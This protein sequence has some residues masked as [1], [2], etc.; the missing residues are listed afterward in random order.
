[1][2]RTLIFA[3]L[4][5]AVVPA[6]AQ[7]QEAACSPLK[8]LA[9]IKLNRKAEFTAGEIGDV[10]TDLELADELGAFELARAQIVPKPVFSI[11]ASAAQGTCRSRESLFRQGR[12][13]S[14]QPSPRRGEG[15]NGGLQPDA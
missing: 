3:A 4:I 12:T 2:H 13:P 6:A 14:P 10:G 7:A 11:G 15:V 8:M 1:M 5:A 9:A